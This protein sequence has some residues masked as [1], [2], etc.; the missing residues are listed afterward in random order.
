MAF[1]SLFEIIKV[2]VREAE[3]EGRSEPKAAVVIPNGV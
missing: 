3:Y 1:I 2:V